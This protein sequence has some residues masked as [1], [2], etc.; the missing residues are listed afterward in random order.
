MQGASEDEVVATWVELTLGAAHHAGRSCQPGTDGDVRVS[1]EQR[2][3]QRHQGVEVGREVDVHVR[4]HVGIGVAPYLPQCSTTTLRI[5]V[6]DP[7]VVEFFGE[8]TCE[9]QRAVDTGVVRDGNS[10]REW[11]LR[12]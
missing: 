10:C 2:S 11:H 9:C 6:D 7:D 8:G 3:N 4:D 5:Q 12:A 1:G